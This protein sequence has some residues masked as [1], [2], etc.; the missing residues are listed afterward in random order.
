VLHHLGLAASYYT[1]LSIQ[2][3]IVELPLQQSTTGICNVYGYL[4]KPPLMMCFRHGGHLRQ[5]EVPLL[6]LVCVYFM[7]VCE[8]L[9]SGQ[10]S[11]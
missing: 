8:R 2:Y 6:Y 11:W 5:D 10:G 7:C 3:S 9:H 4:D 1:T